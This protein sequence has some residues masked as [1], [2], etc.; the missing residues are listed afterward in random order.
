[1]YICEGG[2]NNWE[3]LGISLSNKMKKKNETKSEAWYSASV[4]DADGQ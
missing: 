1:M 2:S 4:V 3:V